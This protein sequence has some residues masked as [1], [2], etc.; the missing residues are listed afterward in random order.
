MVP[1]CT[2]VESFDAADKFYF[3]FWFVILNHK[4]RTGWSCL[5]L[6][7][8]CGRYLLFTPPADYFTIYIDV[9]DVEG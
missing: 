7:G 3:L 9:N 2:A 5:W 1:F 4:G 6:F 8:L